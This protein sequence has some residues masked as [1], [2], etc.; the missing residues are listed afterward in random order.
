MLTGRVERNKTAWFLTA[1]AVPVMQA[2]SGCSWLTSAALGILCLGVCAGLEAMDVPETK[3]LSAVQWIWMTVVL[4]A[5]LEWTLYCWPSDSPVIP[6]TLLLLAVWTAAGGEEQSLRVG[7]LLRFFLIA[8]LGAVLLSG[9]WDIRGENL[10]PNWRMDNADLVTVLLLPTAGVCLGGKG[11][12]SKLFLLALTIAVSAVVTGVLSG[13]F[14][15]IQAS[16]IYELSKSV[17]LLG[18]AERFESLAAAGMT[19][20]YYVFVCWSL[21]LCG[22]WGKTVTGNETAWPVWL[23]AAA[24]FAGFFLKW[25]KT[26][27]FVPAGTV[28]M[29]VFAPLTAAMIGKW[30]KRKKNLKKS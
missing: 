22:R 2:A 20:G 12:G 6:G 3:W 14:A 1:L 8:L 18:V 7:S 27:S 10:R 9:V 23:T 26:G 30:K 24:S 13:P 4:S 29:F 25:P 21:T 19:L 28:I 11:A 15:A 16:A 17:R 5:A